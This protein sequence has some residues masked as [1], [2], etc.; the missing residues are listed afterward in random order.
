MDFVCEIFISCFRYS[1]WIPSGV[2]VGVALD[3]LLGGFLCAGAG[4][5]ALGVGIEAENW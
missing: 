1:S 2:I 4:G 5:W 3:F